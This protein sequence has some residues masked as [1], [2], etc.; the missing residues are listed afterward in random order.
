MLRIRI[1]K[2]AISDINDI[3]EYSSLNWSKEQANLYARSIYNAIDFLSVKPDAGKS[4]SH[5][6]LNH[7]KFRCVSH[8]IIYSVRTDSEVLEIVR[9]LH[10]KM[11]ISKQLSEV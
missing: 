2:V 11:D 10:T 8:W 3:W 4:I 1:S 9:I 7:Y 6:A 5:L